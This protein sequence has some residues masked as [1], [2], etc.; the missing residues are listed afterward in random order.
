MTFVE[1]KILTYDSLNQASKQGFTNCMYLPQSKF[2]LPRA[3]G[4][5]LISNPV[6]DKLVMSLSE[7]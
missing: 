1:V 5:C 4:Q 7:S 2:H 6:L 3:G